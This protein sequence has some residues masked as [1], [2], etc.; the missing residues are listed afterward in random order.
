MYNGSIIKELLDSKKIPYGDLLKALGMNP[1]QT[2]VNTLIRGNPSAK[3]LEEIAD[4]FG[5]PIDTLFIREGVELSAEDELKSMSVTSLRNQVAENER[6]L[7]VANENF[8][9][10]AAA[11]AERFGWTGKLEWNVIYW[12]D[13]LFNEKMVDFR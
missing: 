1:K 2:S 3:R 8:R 9:H 10:V 12:K 5:V 6:L 7:A 11:T 4:F 13:P